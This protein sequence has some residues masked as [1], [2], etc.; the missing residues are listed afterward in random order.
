[1]VGRVQ[2]LWAPHVSECD[3]SRARDGMEQ[4]FPKVCSMKLDKFGRKA[5]Q[6]TITSNCYYPDFIDVE[7]EAKWG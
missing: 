1:M 7:T 4:C 6:P 3:L 5:I 2:H